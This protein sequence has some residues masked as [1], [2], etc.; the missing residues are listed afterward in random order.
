MKFINRKIYNKQ[1]QKNKQDTEQKLRSYAFMATN[2]LFEQLSSTFV[3]ITNQ[4]AENRQNEFGKNIITTD[5]KNTLLHR[6]RE[7]VINPF[8]LILLLIAAVT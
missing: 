8:N 1:I 5:N 2:E 3:G 7:A 4:E 6:L